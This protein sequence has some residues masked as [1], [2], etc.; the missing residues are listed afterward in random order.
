MHSL[1]KFMS[2]IRIAAT[3]VMARTFGRYEHSVCDLDH[4]YARYHWRGRSWAFPTS[5]IRGEH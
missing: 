5:H 3:L 4:E 1:R 2:T